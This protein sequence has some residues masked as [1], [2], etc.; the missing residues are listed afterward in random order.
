M[1]MLLDS[2]VLWYWPPVR[3]FLLWCGARP[4]FVSKT[5]TIDIG[6]NFYPSLT[7]TSICVLL[8]LQA[9]EL[10]YGQF[11]IPLS[12]NDS[13]TGLHIVRSSWWQPML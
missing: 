5:N 1:I 2:K 7:A 8:D 9:G 12:Q 11:W 10:S 13:V 6:L 3:K 4:W